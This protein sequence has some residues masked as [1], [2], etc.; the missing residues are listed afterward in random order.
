VRDAA[1]EPWAAVVPGPPGSPAWAS[2]VAVQVSAAVARLG[3]GRLAVIAPAQALVP[4][5]RALA[6]DPGLAGAVSGPDPVV[7]VAAVAGVK[8]LEYDEVVLC[9]PGA[10]VAASARGVNDLYVA[11]TRPTQRLVVL[12][13]EALPPGL[14]VLAPHPPG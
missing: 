5:R 1:V 11:L 7:T 2:A 13:S 9:E 3:A 4:L 8:G 12:A 14:D 6:A 10:L